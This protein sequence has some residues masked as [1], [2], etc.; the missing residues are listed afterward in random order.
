M[1]RSRLGLGPRVQCH[2]AWLCCYAVGN[3]LR[4]RPTRVYM[5]LRLKNVYG[6]A[7]CAWDPALML[8]VSGY[9]IVVL[10]LLYFSVLLCLCM[11][12]KN[13]VTIDYVLV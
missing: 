1:I 10:S 2:F 5:Y 13:T 3:I 4:D 8:M 9:G 7:I 11:K 12:R 6:L